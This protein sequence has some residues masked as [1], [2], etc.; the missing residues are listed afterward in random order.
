MSAVRIVPAL[1]ACLVLSGCSPDDTPDP[2]QAAPTGLDLANVETIAGGL[3]IP[4]ELAFV[5][6]NTILV[7]ERPGRVR[8]V[9]GGQL[10]AEPV[11]EIDVRR[12]GEAG[13]LG[14]ALHPGFPDERFAYVY[15]TSAEDNRVSRFPLDGGLRFGAEEV[16]LDGIPAGRI[17]DGGRIAFGPDGMLYVGTG[18]A[19]QPELAAELGSLGGKILR[20]LPDG[21]TPD[22]N[23][24][25]NSPV[26]SYGHRNVQGFAWDSRD[27]MY[28]SEH[29][30]SGEL[31]L[32]CHDELNRIEAGSFYGWP[33]RAGN[34]RAGDGS[35][36]A[37]AVAPL[38]ESGDDVWAPAGVAVYEEDG[39]VILFVANLRGE[40]VQSFTLD[41]D[42]VAPTTALDGLGRL[43]AARLGPDGC[44]YLT[45]SNRDGRG[46]PRGEDDRV[47][48]ACS[49]D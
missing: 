27:R 32:C 6:E 11:A 25:P 44:L 19:A 28:A 39:E 37:E 8:V 48:R 33:Y 26:Y 21:S 3:E 20:I 14:I 1:L 12:D 43:R 22:D 4:W 49:A 13:L 30:P 16:I 45:T 41:S 34:S 17:H 42:T 7:T 35:P 2:T 18:D 38:A 46:T 36:P 24:F 47:A 9:E 23:P 29:G 10:R 40:R 31:D 15:Y 5:N